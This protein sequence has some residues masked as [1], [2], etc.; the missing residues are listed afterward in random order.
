MKSAAL[1]FLV[2]L[3]TGCGNYTMSTFY[4]KNTANKPV[5]FSASVVKYSSITGPMVVDQTF[6]VPP[7]DSVL[8][9]RVSLRDNVGPEVWFQKFRIFM[10]EGLSFND[11]KLRDNWVKTIGPDGKPVYTFSLVK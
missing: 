11:P 9:R 5:S 2:L 8:A 6:T 10:A 4:V 1:A 3:L 7:N